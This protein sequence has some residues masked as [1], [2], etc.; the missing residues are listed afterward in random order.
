MDD[1]K[2]RVE[3]SLLKGHS[4]KGMEALRLCSAWRSASITGSPVKELTGGKVTKVSG[5][6]GKGQV[7]GSLGAAEVPQFELT[8]HTPASVRRAKESARHER[9]SRKLKMYMSPDPR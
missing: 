3:S 1:P 8:K 7:L 4:I 5:I 2:T 6:V 9:A